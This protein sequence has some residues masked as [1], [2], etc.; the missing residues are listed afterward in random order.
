[1]RNFLLVFVFLLISA[2]G[3]GQCTLSV[4]IS[5][6]NTSICSGNKV[7]LTANA[8]GGS[9]TLTYVWNTGESTPSINVNKEGTYT[10]TVTDKTPGCP[11]VPKSIDINTGISPGAPT[12]TG[13][14]LVCPGTQA[15]LHATGPG[16]TYQWYD[17][18]ING[19]FLFTGDTYTT[20]PITSGITFYVQ[21]TINGC[22]SLRT[23]VFCDATGNPAAKDVQTCFGTSTTLTA[24]GGSNYQWFDAQTGGTLLGTAANFTT[25]ILT[26]T[27][28]YYVQATIS[29]CLSSRTAVHAIVTPAPQ[30]PVVSNVTICAG[31]TA[32]LHATPGPGI[33]AWYDVQTGGTALILSPDYTTPPLTANKAYWVENVRNGCESART[34]VDVTVNQIPAVPGDQI[35]TTC[36]GSSILLTASASPPPSGTYEWY[37]TATGTTPVATGLSY[38]TPVLNINTTYYVLLNNGGCASGRSKVSVIINPPPAAPSVSGAII[39]YNSSTILTATGPGGNYSWYDVQTGGTALHTGDNFTTPALTANTKYYVETNISGCISPRQPVSVTVTAAVTPPNAAD[40]STCSGSSATL[41][42]SGGGSYAWYS[43][44]AGGTPLATTQAFTTPPLTTQTLYYVERTVN[45]CISARK[46]VTV[47]INPVPANPTVSGNLSVCSGTGTTLTASAPGGTFQWFDASIGGNQVRT[48]ATFIIPSL[49]ATTTYYVQNTV[50]TC[51]SNRT[52]V[53]ITVTSPVEPQF[54]YPSGSVCKLD[55]N[56]VPT[57]NNPSGGTFTAAPAGLLFVSNTTGEIDLAGSSA[58]TY[59]ITFTGNGACAPPSKISFK[60]FSAA[61]ATFSYAAVYCQD[62]ANP[63]PGFG[64]VGS[65]GTFTASPAGLVFVNSSTG[66]IDLKKSTPGPYT[67]TNTVTSSGGCGNDSKTFDVTIDQAVTISA[68]PDQTVAAGT[69]VQLAGSINGVPKGTWSGGTGTFSDKTIPNPVYTPGPG[70]TSATLTYISD[71]PTGSCLPKSDK[72][73]ITFKNTLPK[74]TV[75][76]NST[77]SGSAANLSAIAPGGTYNW[78]DAAGAPVHTGANYLTPVLTTNTT[79]YVETVNAAGVASPRTQVDVTV[80]S[81]PTAPVVPV[82]PVCAG[83]KITLTPNDQ[84]GTFIWYDAATAGNV[85]AKTSTLLTPALTTSQ[86]Y[87]VQQTVNGCPG[88]M[89]Q[90]DVAVTPLASVTSTSIGSVCSGNALNYSITSN[91]AT[92]T[93]LWDRAAVNG[94]SNL[95]VTNQTTNPIT[96]TLINT[97]PNAIDVKYIITPV[98]NGCPGSP[99]TYTVTVYPTPTVTSAAKPP[100]ICNKAPVNYDI[101]FN[102]V[103]DFD[104]SRAAVPG[105]SNTAVSG[106]NTAIIR[107]TLINTSNAPVDVVYIVNSRTATCTGTPFQVTVTVNPSVRI[108]SPE[109]GTAC[110]N[111]PQN[112]VITSN[113]PT[114]TYVW[115]RD[116]LGSPGISNP[117]LS[118]QTSSTITETLINTLPIATHAVYKIQAMANG[119]PADSALFYVV[120]VNPQPVKPVAN[121]NSPI[122]VGSTILLK[123]EDVANGSFLWTGPNGYS[124]TDQNPNIPNATTANVGDYK[125]V[126]TVNGCSSEVSTA[127]VMVRTPSIADAGPDQIVCITDPEIILAGQVKGGTGQGIWSTTSAAPG[128]FSSLTDLNAHYAPSQQERDA[129]KVTFVLTTTSDD[130]CAIST[131]TVVVNFGP[132]PAVNAGPDQSVCSQSPV[133][134]LHGF[135]LLAGTKGNWTT[136]GTGTFS[137]NTDYNAQYFPGAADAA[138]GSVNLVLHVTKNGPCEIETDTVKINFI[139]PATVNA[140]K[141]RYVLRDRT[142]T[143]HPNVSSDSVTYLWTPNINM[144]DNTVKNPVITGV[145]DITY[146]LTVTDIRGCVSSDTTMVKVAPKLVVPNTFTPNND[147]INDIWNITGL[148]AYTDAVVDIYTRYGQKIYHSIG[149]DKPW[150]GIF[151]GKQLPT[152]VYY[153]VID[154]KMFNQ[155]FSGSITLLR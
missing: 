72:V 65:G 68:G 133:I 44:N 151:G 50:G 60:I 137:S 125:L 39:C 150:D 52:P 153:Y 7:L 123:T 79:F 126:V 47:S 22:P 32:S 110:S 90:V 18:P 144:E 119:C 13:N 19:N 118:G 29:G 71:D 26:A 56:P 152:G 67:I 14:T 82:T 85:L 91:I 101:T 84:T 141:I 116:A 41:T 35:Q 8:S 128:K 105:V 1:M 96:E 70:E 117:P 132:L 112:Y 134:Q 38:Q 2:A 115:S 59:T 80:N 99:F 154:T 15:T 36:K 51:V 104:W 108:T 81:V 94:I 28:T 122:C 63:K 16:G 58:G 146:R 30:V 103:A 46:T 25:P 4:S 34:R 100:A 83:N 138:N 48:G 98:N 145:D 97:S 61:N 114:A 129:A 75:T 43:A 106:Q 40:V 95:A 23:G 9:G 64:G 76:G 11:G 27:T 155:V 124:S 102:T 113:I 73:L 3:Y 136:A 78:Y 62:A 140:E 57:I 33:F 111:V 17:A 86:T 54:K 10:V 77:C 31:T 92:A 69:Q 5:A 93:F 121:S 109:T 131:D 107:E 66:E 45:G 37:T 12:V 135:P 87:Y 42:A 21:T 149:Y 143:L 6:S 89:T 88:P 147:G 127:S 55:P 130:D 24:T 120:M 142:I 74:P 148:I 49:N 139:P 53:T 20:P